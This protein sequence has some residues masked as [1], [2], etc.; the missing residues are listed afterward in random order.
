MCFQVIYHISRLK[1]D[2]L[3]YATMLKK[4][5]CTKARLSSVDIKVRSEKLTITYSLQK[6]VHLFKS[7]KYTGY[8]NIHYQLRSEM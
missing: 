6:N 8:T 3:K 7:L 5:R 4:N 1:C 2:F